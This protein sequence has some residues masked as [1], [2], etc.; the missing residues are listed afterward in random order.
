MENIFENVRET[1][2]N[3]LNQS[4]WQDTR[5]RDESI[6]KIKSLKGSFIGADFYLK[7]DYLEDV[8]KNEVRII[9]FKF[10]QL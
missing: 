5:S 8:I 4:H 1:L 6:K 10:I 2:L 9:K 7:S 3:F